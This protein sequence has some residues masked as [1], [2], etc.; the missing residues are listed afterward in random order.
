MAYR[1][2]LLS[3]NDR[4]RRISSVLP[5]NRDVAAEHEALTRAVLARDSDRA[6]E[7]IEAH[8]LETTARV[9][10][11]SSSFKGNLSVTMERLRMQVRAGDGRWSGQLNGSK[12]NTR[13]GKG[14]ALRSLRR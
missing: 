4:Y 12:A 3:L 5:S 13:A 6:V 7:L 1:K 11:G 14:A 8:F 2:K 10:A 9:L